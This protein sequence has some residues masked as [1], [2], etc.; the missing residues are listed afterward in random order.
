[1]SIWCP[2]PLDDGA[3]DVFYHEIASVALHI[4]IFIK[5]NKLVKKMSSEQTPERNPRQERTFTL[6]EMEQILAGPDFMING[7]WRGKELISI[8]QC[9]RKDIEIIIEVSTRFDYEIN[10]VQKNGY[11]PLD[12]ELLAGIF[13]QVSLINYSKL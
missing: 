7:N 10:N 4:D 2:R 5:S 6:Q 11:R 9:T 12:R 1:M 13:T 3:N 8:R